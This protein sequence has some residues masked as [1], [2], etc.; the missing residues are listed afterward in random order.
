MQEKINQWTE[1]AA[2]YLVSGYGV[3]AQKLITYTISE[4]D[5]KATANKIE[6]QVGKD[7]QFIR[8]NG[9]LVGGLVGLVI[10]AVSVML[11]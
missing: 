9:T 7:L 5:P 11:S 6:L 3:E 2:R 4:W 8:I 1:N 10:H